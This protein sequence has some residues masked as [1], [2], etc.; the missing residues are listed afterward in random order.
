[1]VNEGRFCI[2]ELSLIQSY[3]TTPGVFETVTDK[4]LLK[5]SVKNKIFILSTRNLDKGKICAFG[6]QKNERIKATLEGHQ[7]AEKD[8]KLFRGD[9]S[10]II[11]KLEYEKQALEESLK[12]KDSTIFELKYDLSGMNEKCKQLIKF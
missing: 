1:M 4:L 2:I 9:L 11:S 10:Q 8:P 5:I 12:I 3:E 6:N 7:I